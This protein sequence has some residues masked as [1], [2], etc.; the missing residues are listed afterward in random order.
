MMTS[1]GLV[2]R[3]DLEAI[4]AFSFKILDELRDAD[5]NGHEEGTLLEDLIDLNFVTTSTDGREVII[6]L[7]HITIDF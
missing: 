2:D 1:S 4:D 5:V 3:S 7:S 6:P